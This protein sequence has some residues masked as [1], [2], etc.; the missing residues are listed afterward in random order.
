M[1]QSFRDRRILVTPLDWGLGHASRC[2]PV[3]R[4]L[5]GRGAEV[6]IGGG[7]PHVQLILDEFPGLASIPLMNYNIH[8]ARNASL[9]ALKF[10]HMV[11]RVFRCAHR[12]HARLARIIK[13]YAIDGVIADQRFGAFA[14][15]TPSVY[16]THQL[17][18]KT[19]PG[20]GLIER[21]V[22]SGLRYAAN[23]FTVTWIPDYPGE[24]GLT[25]DLTRKYRLP[26]NH[27]FIGPLSRLKP[28]RGE[29]R[30]NGPGI[31]VLLSGPEPQR[32]IL[33][34]RL[35]QQLA[36]QKCDAIVLRGRPAEHT[37]RRLGPV[38]LISHLPGDRIGELMRTAG[39]LICRGGYTT[40]MDCVTLG[41]TAILVPTPGQTEQEYL[42]RRLHAQG[43]FWMEPQA[44]FRLERA[45]D[46]LQ[47]LPAPALVARES[48]LDQALDE[49]GAIIEQSRDARRLF[50]HS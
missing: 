32:S 1:S 11:A 42:C 40:I 28:H 10:P 26:G 5:R 19:P 46:R 3:V 12:E 7:G 39:S 43:R 22:A 48:N 29:S 31:V 45:L 8:Y 30:R 16:I 24:H 15:Q 21:A 41:R 50:A 34:E 20:F 49:L 17:C 6:I 25:G 14:A 35:L 4:R 38:T 13:R 44:C 23:R 18:V 36:Q 2:I 37:E 47:S 27:R 9:L 33:E